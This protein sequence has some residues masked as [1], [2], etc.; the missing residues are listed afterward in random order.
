MSFYFAIRYRHY[1][2]SVFP[3]AY[4]QAPYFHTHAA[5]GVGGSGDANGS[6]GLCTEN[7]INGTSLKFAGGGGGGAY[8]RAVG[9]GMHHHQLCSCVLFARFGNTLSNRLNYSQAGALSVASVGM[10]RQERLRRA[11]QMALLILAVVVAVAHPM[12]VFIFT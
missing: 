4:T 6:G 9:V 5:G 10:P 3:L 11:A 12:Q 1:L 7:S 2:P 8:D